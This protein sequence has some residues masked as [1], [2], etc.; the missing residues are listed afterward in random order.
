MGAS[1]GKREA[2]KKTNAEQLK[3]GWVEYHLSCG[4]VPR[5]RRH[6][7]SSQKVGEGVC[8]YFVKQRTKQ[9]LSALADHVVSKLSDNPMLGQ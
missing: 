5:S 3:G 1:C 2:E 6:L 4:P 7:S 8:R 9:L